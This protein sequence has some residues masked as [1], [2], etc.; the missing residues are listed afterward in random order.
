VLLQNALLRFDGDRYRLLR[1]SVMPNH[2]HVLIETIPG[3]SLHRVLHSWKSFTA[4]MTNRM[5][6]RR[7]MFWQVEYF[8]RYI[9]NADH[10]G[11]TAAYIDANRSR[12]ASASDW[13]RAQGG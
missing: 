9:R 8:D 4:T 6:G 11:A 7:G 10:L 1:W 12:F 13:Q 2:V 5:L 3:Y